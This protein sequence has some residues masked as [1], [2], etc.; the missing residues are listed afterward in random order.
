MN[1]NSYRLYKFFQGCIV[2]GA[3]LSIILVFIILF[4]DIDKEYF[5]KI[6]VAIAM[7]TSTVALLSSAQ[8]TRSPKSEN[9]EILRHQDLINVLT[10]ISTNIEVLN[11]NVERLSFEQNE[12][13]IN[14]FYHNNIAYSTEKI[15]SA[16]NNL[17]K[18]LEQMNTVQDL[19]TDEQSENHDR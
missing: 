12:S 4:A 19:S 14:E 1:K 18:V 9:E 5:T 8:N 16:V 11:G 3:F 15:E 6:Q 2:V 7:C 13:R 17:A 10:N